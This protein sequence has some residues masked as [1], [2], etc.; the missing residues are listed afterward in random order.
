MKN[1]TAFF[2]LLAF[3]ASSLF[4][5]ERRASSLGGEIY[6]DLLDLQIQINELNN[7]LQS[8]DESLSRSEQSARDLELL[9]SE[10]DRLLTELQNLLGRREQTLRQLSLL[11]EEQQAAYRKSLF[12][13]KFT[14]VTLGILSAGLAGIVIYQAVAR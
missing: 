8:L 14:T 13:W 10:K 5:Q 3:A 7:H 12:K 4:S 11:V 6:S 9:A 1:F 2:L